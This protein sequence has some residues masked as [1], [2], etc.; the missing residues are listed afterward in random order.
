MSNQEAPFSFTTK[1]NGDLFTVRGDTFEQFVQNLTQCASVAQIA[2]LIDALDGKVSTAQAV[3]TVQ[4]VFPGAQVVQD[5]PAVTP[6][7][8]Q[9]FAPVPPAAPVAPPAAPAAGANCAHGPMKLMPA[10]ISK[11]TGKPY[12]AFYAC[13]WPTREEQCK[14][15][16]VA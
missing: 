15:Q 13:Q 16:P 8:A 7:P 6:F 3:E 10:G 14:T 11:K 5:T 4:S 2:G 12:N 9:Q 1:V